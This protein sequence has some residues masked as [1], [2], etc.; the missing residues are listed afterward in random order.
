MGTVLDENSFCDN[1]RDY[2]E[3]RL[4]KIGTIR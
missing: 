3:A 2:R 1:G 4:D